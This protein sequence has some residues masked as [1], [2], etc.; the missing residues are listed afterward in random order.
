MTELAPELLQFGIIVPTEIF[1]GS[2]GKITKLAI[3]EKSRRVSMAK[4][5]DYMIEGFVYLGEDSISC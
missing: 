5:G 2:G 3:S 1:I 4:S